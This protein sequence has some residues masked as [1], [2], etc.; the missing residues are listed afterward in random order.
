[1]RLVG[2]ET[3]QRKVCHRTRCDRCEHFDHFDDICFTLCNGFMSGTVSE[4]ELTDRDKR[5]LG[6]IEPQR[7]S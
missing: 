7:I 6:W 4:D 2:I 3:F 1:M 5:L